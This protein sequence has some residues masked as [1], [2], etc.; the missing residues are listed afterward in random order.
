[1]EAK[2]MTQ[3]KEPSPLS[4]TN[5]GSANMAVQWLLGAILLFA[6]LLRSGQSALAL[7]ALETLSVLLLAAV[8]WRPRG[9]V[10]AKS[11]ALALTLLI[12][13]PVLYLLPLPA[14]LVEWLPGR[15]PYLNAQMLLDGDSGGGVARLSL[16]PTKTESVLLLLLLPV[17]VILGTRV[18]SSTQTLQLVL[19]VLGVAALLS[20]LGLIQYGTGAETPLPQGMSSPGIPNALGTYAG[21]NRLAGLLEMALPLAFALMFFSVGH[22]RR[23]PRSETDAQA[24]LVS[25]VR[26]RAPVVYGSVALLL[27]IG[28][29][30]TRSRSGIAVRSQAE[31]T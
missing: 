23:D 14:A 18:L 21:C 3:G 30:L 25:A 13:I 22:R 28:A 27:L 16:Y 1:M 8:L 4:P 20:L 9:N 31:I 2:W 24:T 19:L 7:P 5:T 17:A 6:P 29:I 11:Q 12:A 15:Q 10:I 26:G